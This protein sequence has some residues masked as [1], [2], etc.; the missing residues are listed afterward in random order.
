MPKTLKRTHGNGAERVALQ[1]LRVAARQVKLY[2]VSPSADIQRFRPR[3]SQKLRMAGLFATRSKKSIFNSW[4]GYVADKKKGPKGYAN[5]TL[6]TLTVPWDVYQAADNVIPQAIEKI[7]AGEVSFGAFGWDAELFIPE[8]F[9]DQIKVVSRSTMHSQEYSSTWHPDMHR[10]PDKSVVGQ[11]HARLKS[12]L[13]SLALKHRL[14]V[15]RIDRTV[16]KRFRLDVKGLWY[17]PQAPWHIRD[18]LTRAEKRQVQKAEE[19]AK[20]YIREQLDKAGVERVA[21]QWLVARYAAGTSDEARVVNAAGSEKDITANLPAFERAHKE[22]VEA[23]ADGKKRGL[24]GDSV[25]RRWANLPWVELMQRGHLIAEGIQG[26]RS[27][28]AR[29][30]KGMEMAHRLYSRSRAMPKDVYK[31]WGTNEKRILLTLEAAKTWPEKKEGS[32]DLFRVGPFLVHNTIGI[33]GSKLEVFKK[34]LETATKKIKSDR[35]VPGIKKVLYG[36]VYLVG[37]IAGAH[38]A[39]WYNIR[40][41]VIYCRVAK[42]KWGFDEAYSL[43]HELCHRYW[44]KFMSREAKAKWE[45]HHLAVSYRKVEIP[46]PKVGDELPVRIKGAPRG[47]RPVLKEITSTSYS[48]ERP[49]GVMGGISKTQ[50]HSFL[51]KTRGAE[52][53]FPTAYSAKNEEEHFCEAVASDAFG[54]LG[55]DHQAALKGIW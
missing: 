46:R 36:D 24:A 38:A 18:D 42:A 22:F 17:A 35:T 19:A 45:S 30:A 8:Q 28:P 48:Y 5:L 52:L 9:M 55:D 32:D 6:Y 7:E 29:S 47:W 43:V 53:R 11:A 15:T 50:L 40:E 33:T 2:H 1:W 14:D 26:T 39:A 37:K 54:S 25:V 3:W 23:L 12:L 21:L 13:S 44:R 51:S 4:S 27:T 34:M 16:I 10:R 31:W 49:N 41:D 20:A